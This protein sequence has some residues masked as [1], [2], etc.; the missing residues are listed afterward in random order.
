[1]KKP[2]MDEIQAILI[3][4]DHDEIDVSPF[5]QPED[6]QR[7]ISDFDSWIEGFGRFANKLHTPARNPQSNHQVIMRKDILPNRLEILRVSTVSD[8]LIYFL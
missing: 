6:F 1:M 3:G 8:N 2:R 7:K 4:E 5:C